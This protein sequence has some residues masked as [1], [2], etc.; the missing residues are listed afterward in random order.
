M[1]FPS[2]SQCLGSV[3]DGAVT[4]SGNITVRFTWSGN[5]HAAKAETGIQTLNHFKEGYKTVL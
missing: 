3:K 2:L 1:V 4:D 5:I